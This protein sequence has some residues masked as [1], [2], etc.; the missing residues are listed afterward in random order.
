MLI[1]NIKNKIYVKMLPS[2]DSPG[3][4]VVLLASRDVPLVQCR[5]EPAYLQQQQSIDVSIL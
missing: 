1:F 2:Y 5:Q 3:Y 4:H